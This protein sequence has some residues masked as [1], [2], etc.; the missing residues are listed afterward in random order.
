MKPRILIADDSGQL[1]EELQGI[2]GKRKVDLAI[3]TTMDDCIA[4]A[5]ENRPSMMVVFAGMVRAFSLLRMLRRSLDLE[6]IPLVVVASAEQEELIGKHRKLPSRA[7]RY[8]LRPLDPELARSVIDDLLGDVPVAEGVERPVPPPLP[9]DDEVAPAA[10]QRME[11]ELHSYQERVKELERDLGIML[12]A[13]REA[14]SLRE[15]NE[16]LRNELAETSEAEQTPDAEQVKLFARLESGYKDT[17]EDL[18]RLISDKDEVIARLAASDEAGGEESRTLARQ[19]ERE[20]SRFGELMKMLRQLAAVLEQ[21][22]EAERQVDIEGLLRKLK[23]QENEAERLKGSLAFDEETLVVEA[24]A[25]R[26]E[27]ERRNQ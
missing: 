10:Y 9:S 17:I 4:E 1:A 2:F 5:R 14:T 13:T 6:E 15:E 12:K 11:E 26:R 7:D 8:L 21:A 18:E 3:T 24:D 23:A 20:Q 22:A 19:L 16:R 27:L 25:L